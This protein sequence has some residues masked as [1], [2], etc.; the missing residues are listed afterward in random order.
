[1]HNK[2]VCL[3]LIFCILFVFVY[4]RGRSLKAFV[5]LIPIR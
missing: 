5:Y 3:S 4:F 2:V 1:M